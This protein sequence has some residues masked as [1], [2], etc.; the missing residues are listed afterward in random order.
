MSQ[1]SSRSSKILTSFSS[2]K[3]SIYVNNNDNPL[4]YLNILKSRKLDKKTVDNY[5][6]DEIILEGLD[7]LYMSVFNFI[8][9]ENSGTIR[10]IIEQFNL[11]YDNS[12]DETER[13]KNWKKFIKTVFENIKKRIIK[14]IEANRV[15]NKIAVTYNEARTNV[16]LTELDIL[17]YNYINLTFSTIN[18]Y[19][20][21]TYNPRIRLITLRKF[22]I[23]NTSYNLLYKH[24]YFYLIDITKNLRYNMAGIITGI[25][26]MFKILISRIYIDLIKKGYNNYKRIAFNQK[27]L[28]RIISRRSGIQD[29]ADEIISKIENPNKLFERRGL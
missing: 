23:A 9:E 28:A 22:I 11:I 29:T 2:A 1:S 4:F 15:A 16:T 17:L 13:I 10:A 26:E 12:T 27:T 14:F 18:I 3:D 19:S 7:I 20:G 5:I 6:N 8:H 21:V 25:N 24:F